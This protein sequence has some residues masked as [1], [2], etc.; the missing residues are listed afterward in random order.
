VR[1]AEKHLEDVTH[2]HVAMVDD[3]VKHKEAELL[4]V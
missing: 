2:R 3:M 4:E 1:R